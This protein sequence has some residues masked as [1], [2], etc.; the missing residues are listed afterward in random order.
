M[1]TGLSKKVII[2]RFLGIIITLAA[3]GYALHV[4]LGSSSDAGIE[5]AQQIDQAR[6]A[7]DAMNQALQLQ[8]QKFER[9]K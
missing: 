1:I 7:A 9:A 2:M 6:Q 5:Q 3:V 8:Q 4:Y